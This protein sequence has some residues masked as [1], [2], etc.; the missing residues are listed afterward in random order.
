MMAGTKIKRTKNTRI[1][2]VDVVRGRLYENYLT[3]KFISRN[4]FNTKILQIT[5]HD[6][7]LLAGSDL[8]CQADI[9]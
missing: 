1:Y 6:K 5:V 3:Q 7:W 2:N 4:I 8:C 9:P